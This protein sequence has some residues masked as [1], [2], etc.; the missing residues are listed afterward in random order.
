MRSVISKI[1]YYLSACVCFGKNPANAPPRSFIFFPC[2]PNLLCCG[3]AGIVSFKKEHKDIR[4]ADIAEIEKSIDGMEAR[5]FDLCEKNNLSVG[6]N[7][8]CG[9]EFL[10]SLLEKA[11]A[12][13]RD[14]PFFE[15]FTKKD[16]QDKIGT[17]SERI[18]RITESESKILSGRMGQLEPGAV[19]IMS[20]RIE[21]LKYLA[22]IFSNEISLNILKIRELLGSNGVDPPF[23]VTTLYKKINAVLNSIDRLEVRGRD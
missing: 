14:E 19:E 16:L 17:L 7:Y 2:S 10:D 1:I 13:K 22:W 21:D 6:D 5:I 12:L 11:R 15:I 20:K 4:G 18:G 8:L 9:G 3:L 23:A